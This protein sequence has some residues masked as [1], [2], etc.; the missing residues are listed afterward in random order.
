MSNDAKKKRSFQFQNLQVTLKVGANKSQ[1]IRHLSLDENGPSK[2]V[3]LSHLPKPDSVELNELDKINKSPIFPENEKIPVKILSVKNLSHGNISLVQSKIFAKFHSALARTE[4]KI[5]H[6]WPSWNCGTLF[7]FFRGSSIVRA[8][9]V[10]ILNSSEVLSHL[11]DLDEEVVVSKSQKI[12]FLPKYFQDFNPLPLT[13]QLVLGEHEFPADKALLSSDASLTR[14][15]DFYR[16]R[17]CN[18]TFRCSCLTAQKFPLEVK[19]QS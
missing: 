8:Q 19:I 10:Q 7:A 12:F 14:K 9:V 13:A 5:I 15:S 18:S 1:D 4:L 6:T 3:N 11:I 2:I 17:I 16:I